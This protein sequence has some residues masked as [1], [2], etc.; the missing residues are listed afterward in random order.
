MYSDDTDGFL[1]F[2]SIQT[3]NSS[4]V[5]NEASLTLYFTDNLKIQLFNIVCQD[6]EPKSRRKE[7]ISH[8]ILYVNYIIGA[9]MLDFQLIMML[10]GYRKY[11]S[12]IWIRQQ[13]KIGKIQCSPELFSVIFSLNWTKYILLYIYKLPSIA[14]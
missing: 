14:G 12:N 9:V 1:N 10:P 8:N 2:W 7:N 5:F 11:L 4:D 13:V 3:W 6:P